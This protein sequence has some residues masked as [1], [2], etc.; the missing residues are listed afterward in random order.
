MGLKIAVQVDLTASGTP[1]DVLTATES[2]DIKSVLFCNR[3]ATQITVRVLQSVNGAA[4]TNA[5]YWF[6]DHILPPNFTD[7]RPLDV[8]MQPG[9]VIRASCSGAGISMSLW[10]TA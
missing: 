9:D 7:F 3:T 4:T 2:F 6:Y 8:G 10:R 1:A 5:Q